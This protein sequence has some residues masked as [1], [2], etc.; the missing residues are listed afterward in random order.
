MKRYYTSTIC[1]AVI[2][3]ASCAEDVKVTPNTY[4]QVFTG[5]HSKTWKVK[6]FEQTLD[7]NVVETFTVDCTSDDQFTFNAGSEHAYQVATGSK[8]CNSDPVEDDQI[9][10]T[11]DFTNSSA[12]MQMIF[13]VFDP[14]SRLPFIVREAKSDKMTLEIFFDSSG[15]ESYRIHFESTQES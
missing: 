11:W 7:G 4:T 1:A 8:K 3:M 2:L 6:F 15:K 14:T 5:Q 13:P 9:V 12:T 10:D